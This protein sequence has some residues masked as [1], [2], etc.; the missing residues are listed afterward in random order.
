M[1]NSIFPLGRGMSNGTPIGLLYN[2]GSRTPFLVAFGLKETDG[3]FT[4]RQVHYFS[5]LKAAMNKY[6]NYESTG[7]RNVEITR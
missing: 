6:F 1:E 2:K 5:D 7:L 3:N 4:W